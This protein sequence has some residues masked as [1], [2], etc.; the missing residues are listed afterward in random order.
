M[1][2]SLEWLKRKIM[3]A[4]NDGEDMEPL[5]L[6]YIVGESVNGKIT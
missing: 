1:R 6:S 2:K 5:E 4:S 3:T